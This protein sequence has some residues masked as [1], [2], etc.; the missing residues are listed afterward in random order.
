MHSLA[1][2]AAALGSLVVVLAGST[3]AL[4]WHQR[5]ALD[6]AASKQAQLRQAGQRLHDINSMLLGTTLP[7]TA[8][9]CA[10]Y[11]HVDGGRNHYPYP[12]RGSAGWASVMSIC[13][14]ANE[15]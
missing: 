13:S 9:A 14:H 8:G 12:V 1:R 4:A 5:S 11:A 3:G 7:P 10:V 6:H 15:R 2:W